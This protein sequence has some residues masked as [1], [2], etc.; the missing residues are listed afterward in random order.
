MTNN[1]LNKPHY[2]EYIKNIEFEIINIKSNK[3][4][5]LKH[6]LTNLI[7]SVLLILITGIQW[8]YSSLFYNIPK[9]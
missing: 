4:R 7:K 5:P 8:E 6:N 9:R 2:K 1:I 3:G